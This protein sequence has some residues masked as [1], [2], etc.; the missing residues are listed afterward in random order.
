MNTQNKTTSI[1]V[2]VFLLA[3]TS[4]LFAQEK[5]WDEPPRRNWFWEWLLG[6]DYYSGNHYYTDEDLEKKINLSVYWQFSIGDNPDWASPKYKDSN[7]EKIYVPAKWENEGFNGYDGYAW[8]RVHFDGK[9]LNPNEAHFLLPGFIDDV[10]ETYVNGT[11]V[12]KSGALPPRFRT[13][14]NSD[15][16]YFIPNQVINFNG[17]NVIAIR[18]Y[19]E[20]LDGGIVG[21]KPG[22]YAQKHSEILLQSL[23]GPWK[24]MPT[25]NSDFSDPSYDDS[26]WENLMVPSFWDNQG[27]RSFDGTGWYRKSFALDFTLNENKRYY[28]I[29]GKI[30]DFDVTYLNGTKI[31]ETN[32]GKRL[33]ES[34]SYNKLR[35]YAIPKGLLKVN[36]KNVVSV[37]VKDIGKDGGIYKGPIGIVEESDVTKIIRRD[38]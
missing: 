28:L 30:D 11:L 17:D 16:K 22:I 34:Q 26:E 27:F 31:G 2:A 12:G 14:Y 3:A 21:G 36:G 32:D 38:Y 8:Y 5:G 35:V 37:K 9:E 23:Y 33:G 15:R 7:W 13:A 20:I 25:N 24:F 29:L 18:V 6:S 19:D 1:L 10:D 4:S